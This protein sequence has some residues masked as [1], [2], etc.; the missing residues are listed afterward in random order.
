MSDFWNSLAGSRRD[1]GAREALG[2]VYALAELGRKTGD[3]VF[4]KEIL[5]VLQ[6][7]MLPKTKVASTMVTGCS[8]TAMENR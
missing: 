7:E 5:A 4:Y 8:F 1:A 3:P 2:A 6:E